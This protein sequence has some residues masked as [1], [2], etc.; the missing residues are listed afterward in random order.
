LVNDGKG[1]HPLKKG[2]CHGHCSSRR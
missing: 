1:S 2:K